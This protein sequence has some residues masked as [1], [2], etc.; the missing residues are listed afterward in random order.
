MRRFQEQIA[1]LRP[2]SIGSAYRLAGIW[3]WS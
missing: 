1:K 2:I 3:L